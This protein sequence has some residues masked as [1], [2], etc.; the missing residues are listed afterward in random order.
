MNCSDVHHAI[1]EGRADEPSVLA[2]AETCDSCAELLAESGALGLALADLPVLPPVLEAPRPDRAWAAIQSERG[3]WAWGRGLST[4]VKAMG[5]VVT[6]VLVLAGVLWGHPRPDL[7]AYPMDRMALVLGVLGAVLGIVAWARMRPLHRAPLTW[8]TSLVLA[9]VAIPLVV[10][11][12]DEAVTGHM[13]SMNKGPFWPVTI[14]CFVTGSGLGLAVALLAQW[15]ERR[16]QQPLV[17]VGLSA[18]AMGL[19]G[20]IAMQ[21]FCPI[22]DPMHLLL[23]HAS[24]GV[25]W[26]IVAVGI[27]WMVRSRRR[28]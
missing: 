21:L 1:R 8:R 6:V 27:A 16:Q 26:A 4:P 14:N 19:T 5:M 12:L 2:H 23:G 22:T 9:S 28:A 24:I 10:A 20:N 13:A 18:A 3:F 7:A 15:F 17:V 11:G 25:A